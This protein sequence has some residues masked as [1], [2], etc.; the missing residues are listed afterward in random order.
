MY[1]TMTYEIHRDIYYNTK[2]SSFI[3]GGATCLTL[4]V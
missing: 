2:S 4:L 1:Y 3:S